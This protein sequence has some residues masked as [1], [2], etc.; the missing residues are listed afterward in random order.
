V[1]PAGRQLI[2]AAIADTIIASGA[3]EDIPPVSER[4]RPLFK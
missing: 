2:A 4:E 1:N 3:L